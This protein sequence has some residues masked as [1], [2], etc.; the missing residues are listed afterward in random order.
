MLGLVNNLK[1]KFNLQVQR[2]HCENAGKN[3]GFKRTCKQEELGIDFE[4]TAPGTPQ[5]NGCIKCKFAM[6]FNRVCAVLNDGRFTA[7]LQ[8]SLWAEAANTATLLENN[9]ITPN[10][11]LSPFQ[12]YFGKRQ[13][14]VLALM[15]KFGEM[16]IAAFKDNTHWA[17]L[18][19][20]G[21]PR[22]WVGYAKNHPAGTCQIFNPQTEKIILTRDVTFLQK[23]YGELWRVGWGGGT[24]NSSRNN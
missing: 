1:N 17:K 16:C 11:T 13:K 19:T 2:L 7:Y 5:Q 18:A 8:S 21:T 23:S 9:L 15:Q 24:Q 10:R 14:N 3:R 12:Q 20:C 4:Y 22:M 6:L